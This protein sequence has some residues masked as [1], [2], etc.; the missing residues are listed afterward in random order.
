MVQSPSFA[1]FC[2]VATKRKAPLF[3]EYADLEENKIE[4]DEED[5][6]ADAS[7]AGE[8]GKLAIQTKS[9]ILEKSIFNMLHEMAE[10]YAHSATK[11]KW[12]EVPPVQPKAL[13]DTEKYK[14]LFR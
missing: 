12:Y 3:E 6:D 9:E 5:A 13:I 11:A 14:D 7:L 1:S 2:R 10:R 4:N 8:D